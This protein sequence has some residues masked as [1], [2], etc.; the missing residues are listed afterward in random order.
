MLFPQPYLPIGSK[1]PAVIVLQLM[2]KALDLN[3]GL[4]ADGDYGEMTAGAIRQIQEDAGIEEDGNF[5]PDTRK[6][7]LD[8]YGV[9]VNAIPDL[10]GETS[11]PSNTDDVDT[12]TLDLP[13][14]VGKGV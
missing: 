14:Q 9:D 5:G 7:F 13:L 11:V 8:E 4:I 12:A 2:L 3:S 6:A 1:G 10:S